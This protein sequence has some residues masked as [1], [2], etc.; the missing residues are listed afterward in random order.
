MTGYACFVAESSVV[1]I[2]NFDG[3]HLGHRTLLDAA[4]AVAARQG[5]AVVAMAFDPHPAGA[6]R[7]GSEPP[8]LASLAD[9]R[10]ALLDAGADRV[11][12]IEPTRSLLSQ[13]PEQFVQ[14]LCREHHPTAVVEGA[15]FR[16]GEGRRGDMAM[17][18]R[19][20]RSLGFEVLTVPTFE[21][22]LA[23]L[24]ICPARSSMIRWLL[25][26]GRGD[27]AARCL[28]RLYGLDGRVVVGDKRGRTI[29]VPTVNL[30]PEAMADFMI[31]SEGVYAGVVD[32]ADG[33]T[34]H[35][36]IS[37]GAKPTFGADSP[38]V[39]A[40]LLNFDGD[41]YDSSIRIRFA[42]WVRDQQAFPDLAG[43]CRQLERDI[44][45]TRRWADL[46]LLDTGGNT[47]RQKTAAGS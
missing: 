32:L 42:R 8:R 12:V 5:A 21:I 14:W 10:A 27:D 7:P 23:D 22:P 20:G 47:C 40:H 46:G 44:E 19:L 24:T 18:E 43:L 41:L 28:G 1:T 34:R 3:V 9:K 13:S 4:R 45:L 36:A 15:D 39:E 11:V 6:L 30:D 35:A 38:V 37:I 31:P 16:F 33:Q 29:G 17:L 2:G 26:C 25:D